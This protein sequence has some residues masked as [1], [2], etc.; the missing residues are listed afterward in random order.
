MNATDSLLVPLVDAGNL[1]GLKHGLGSRYRFWR[2]ESG[3]RHV[4]SVYP[5]DA[6]PDYPDA[7]AVVTRRTPAG[8]I[9]MWAGPA[10]EAARTA[11]LRTRGDE[12]HIHVFG[13]EEASALRRLMDR[14]TAVALPR[15]ATL[16]RCRN[17][18]RHAA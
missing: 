17:D 6:A 1:N 13:D 18:R 10:G 3:V 5:A 2:D 12:I 15:S 11:A 7:L 9:A 8:A 4:F 14:G 16:P